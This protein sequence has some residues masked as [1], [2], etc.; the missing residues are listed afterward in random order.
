MV[1]PHPRGTRG[2]GGPFLNWGGV[3]TRQG[4]LGPSGGGVG[5]DAGGPRGQA[6]LSL[7]RVAGPP[8]WP[9]SGL[10]GPGS[11]IRPWANG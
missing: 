10:P 9:S 3:G 6:G 1:C 8:F 2:L 11:R 4:H 5:A 7:L